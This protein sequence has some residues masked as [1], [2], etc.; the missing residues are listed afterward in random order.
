MLPFTSANVL[1]QPVIILHPYLDLQSMH[2]TIFQAVTSYLYLPPFLPHSPFEFRFCPRQVP[3]SGDRI[4]K[5]G[6]LSGLVG[7][8]DV[9]KPTDV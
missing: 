4:E 2:T 6:Y 7:G 3:G 5:K 9:K 8:L 1:E